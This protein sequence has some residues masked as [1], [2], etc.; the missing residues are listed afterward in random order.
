VIFFFHAIFDLQ[1]LDLGLSSVTKSIWSSLR[2]RYILTCLYIFYFDCMYRKILQRLQHRSS[3]IR[4]I[5][6]NK[7]YYIY[8]MLYVWVH[9]PVGLVKHRDLWTKTKLETWIKF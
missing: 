6:I 2:C 4:F 5:K 3:F 7:C 1:P 8:W 9:I